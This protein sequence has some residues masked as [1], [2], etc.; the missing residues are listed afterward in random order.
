MLLISFLL[1]QRT[2]EKSFGSFR[3]LNLLKMQ[4]RNETEAPEIS[5]KYQ[6][7][8]TLSPGPTNRSNSRVT[9]FISNRQEAN[10]A[11]KQASIPISRWRPFALPNAQGG[12]KL[13]YHELKSWNGCQRQFRVATNNHGNCTLRS[14]DFAVKFEKNSRERGKCWVGREPGFEPG[15][16]ALT[17]DTASS[18]VW[19]RRFLKCREKCFNDIYQTWNM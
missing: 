15:T 9:L 17:S 13:S 1:F 11:A 18:F 5:W 3:F 19:P 8:R 10:F 2:A 14:A 4:K 7:I 12:H 6:D 16:L